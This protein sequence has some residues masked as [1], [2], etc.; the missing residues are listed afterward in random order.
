MVWAARSVSVYTAFLDKAA[1]YGMMKPA[2]LR[3]HAGRLW[4]RVS[5]LAERL[6]QQLYG[7]G[8]ILLGAIRLMLEFRT[9]LS[10]AA[11]AYFALLAIFPLTL[12]SIAIASYSLGPSADL[13]AIIQRLE[14]LA[15]T[16]GDLMSE[17]IA[18]VIRARGSVSLVAL[19]T[20][21]WSAS[22][23]FRGLG[24]ILREIW[25]AEYIR[26][27]WQRHGIAIT[28]ILLLVG[29]FVILGFLA[30]SLFASLSHLLPD[31]LQFLA[32]GLSAVLAVLL[33]IVLFWMLYAAMPHGAGSWSDLLTG[34]IGAGLL[35]EAAKRG[36][37]SFVGTYMSTTNLVYGSVASI[38]AFL[39]WSYLSGL[40]LL[41]GA[42][43]SVG[44]RRNR[45]NREADHMLR[46]DL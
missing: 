10:A 12:L 30:G 45:I 42:Y 20:L 14:F 6:D 18:G 5:R 8:G 23:F 29:P 34:A 46:P 13:A 22:S 25:G 33:N 16:L 40:I 43:L 11:V 31:Q 26:P 3:A 2:E 28:L 1:Q 19:L 21:V 7:A 36:F 15:P 39:A 37:V 41:F 38:I 35:W 27:Y 17:N 32:R 44:C 24:G 4:E 9:T